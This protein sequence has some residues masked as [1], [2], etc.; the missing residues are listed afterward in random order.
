M[1]PKKKAKPKPSFDD[2]KKK[3]KKSAVKR[4]ATKKGY[5]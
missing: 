2:F 4:T 3:G 5:K 1:A